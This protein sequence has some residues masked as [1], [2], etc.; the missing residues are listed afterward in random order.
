MI[1]IPLSVGLITQADPEEVGINGCTQLINAEFDK[2]GRI[3]KRPGRGASITSA[4]SIKHIFKWMNSWSGFTGGEVWIVATTDGKLMY[5]ED[6]Q[7]YTEIEDLGSDCVDIRP[8]NHG[9]F[10]R[11]AGGLTDQPL[12][13]QAIDRSF[14]YI[15]ETTSLFAYDDLHVGPPPTYPGTFTVDS[16]DATKTLLNE[17]GG[18]R[19]PFSEDAKSCFYKFTAVFDGNQE[20]PF[21][22]EYKAFAIAVQDPVAS[23]SNVQIRLKFDERDWDPRITSI[24]MYRAITDAE[25]PDD[26]LYQKINTFETTQSTATDWINGIGETGKQ[27]FSGGVAIDGDATTS[28]KL[29]WD[30]TEA[31]LIATTATLGSGSKHT[32][33]EVHPNHLYIADDFD[34]SND[35]W[36]T[37]KYWHIRDE[38]ELVVNGDFE[39]DITG[40]DTGVGAY[41]QS[42]TEAKSGSSS[43]KITQMTTS[44]YIQSTA[45]IVAEVDKEYIVSAWAD[46][47]KVSGS[48]SYLQIRLSVYMGGGYTVL[49]TVQVNS[50]DSFEQINGKFTATG[51]FKI[52]L[53]VHYISSGGVHINSVVYL[54]AIQCNKIIQSGSAVYTGDNVFALESSGVDVGAGVDK[55]AKVGASDH[56]VLDNITDVFKVAGTPF[57][58]PE[59][60]ISITSAGDQWSENEYDSRII[61]LDTYDTGQPSGVYHPLASVSSTEVNYKYSVTTDGRNFVAG[62]KLDPNGAQPEEHDNW[63]IFSELNQYDILPISN[64]IQLRDLQ[65]GAITGLAS[66]MGD[67]VVFMERGIYRLS[68]PSSDP[69]AWSLSESEENIGCVSA[70]SIV[71]WGAGVF[72]AGKDHIYYLDANFNATPV[73]Q[74]IKADYQSNWTSDVTLYLETKKN[75]LV[76]NFNSGSSYTYFLDLNSFPKEVWTQLNT[77]SIE[78]WGDYDIVFEDED[79]NAYSY[80]SA[81]KKIRPHDDA[82]VEDVGFTRATGWINGSD[83]GK[84]V[85]IRRLNF[86]YNSECEIKVAIYTDG[87][88]STKRTWKNGSTIQTLPVNTSGDKYIELIPGIRCKY[89]MI[90]IYTFDVPDAMEINKIEVGFE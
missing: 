30:T 59:A 13:V 62:I 84:S 60:S 79:L 47:N 76:C 10:L 12:I 32:I 29:Y 28:H 16:S 82:S 43:C 1:E 57:E 9:S 14:F 42:S 58:D 17:G 41:A 65:G 38:E 89:F 74:S 39:S 51:N 34:G 64:Y 73:T 56:I 26:A 8:F 85:L 61:Y 33:S 27:V 48:A 44:S 18:G 54:D 46:Y 6:L 49:N 81:D 72:F 52:K 63:I 20:L 2:M 75:R 78:S 45:E 36:G 23:N 31:T 55:V 67:L 83:L 90:K 40:W 3:Y 35:Y 77:G 19:L 5:T 66:L 4:E 22:D 68:V 7:T 11:C 53:A 25:V 21:K 71:N 80:N 50:T 69:T 88:T 15:D 24:N 87:D 86:R 70:D 37:T